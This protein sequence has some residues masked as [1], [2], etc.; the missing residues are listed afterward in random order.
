MAFPKLS[1]P[2]CVKKEQLSPKADK[3]QQTLKGE[4]PIR[5]LKVKL[6][7]IPLPLSTEIKSKRTSPAHKIS[8][9]F[10]PFSIPYPSK[11]ASLY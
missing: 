11:K 5:F 4:P 2:N 7:P 9:F 6:S 3:P 1:S 10:E 8:I